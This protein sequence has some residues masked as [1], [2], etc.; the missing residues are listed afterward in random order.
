MKNAF[1]TSTQSN[2]IKHIRTNQVTFG[3]KCLAS[4]AP[5]IWNNLPIKRNW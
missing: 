2:D 1:K 3:S 4:V 5:Q